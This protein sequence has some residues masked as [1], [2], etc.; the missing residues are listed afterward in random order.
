VVYFSVR[1][2]E[3]SAASRTPAETRAIG[4]QVGELLCPGDVVCLAGP[5]GAGKTTLAQG[6]AAG[7]GVG[8]PVCSP[9]FTL[10][11]EYPGRLPLWHVDAYRLR[12]AAEALDLG[13]DEF[14]RLGGVTLIEW[15]ERIG[16]ALPGERL[17]ALL[18]MGE[19][20]ERQIRF[21]SHGE[22]ASEI[23]RALRKLRGGRTDSTGGARR[24]GAGSRG[25]RRNAARPGDRDVGGA[26]RGGGC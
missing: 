7:L 25:G 3:W 20:D 2:L 22:R 17:D 21:R 18:S 12:G 26:L 11:Q 23:V 13:L 24:R 14:V 16:G 10:I 19:G 6:I 5:M 15:P 1:K 9:T 8:E 4:S